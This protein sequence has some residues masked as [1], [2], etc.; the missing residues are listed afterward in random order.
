MRRLRKAD[1]E[2]MM[3]AYDDDPVGALTTALQ[4]TLGLPGEHWTALVKAA[5]FTCARRIRLQARETEALDEL[6]RELNE[7]RVLVDLRD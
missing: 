3:A 7:M 2:R 1:V 5:G 6:L 4:L